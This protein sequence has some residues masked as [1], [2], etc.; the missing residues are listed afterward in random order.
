MC[1]GKNDQVFS[2]HIERA[3]KQGSLTKQGIQE[4]LTNEPLIQPK[5]RDAVKWKGQQT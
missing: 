2:A 4:E 1:Y 5:G 3:L